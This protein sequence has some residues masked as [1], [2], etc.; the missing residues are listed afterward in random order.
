MKKQYLPVILNNK[1]LSDYSFEY[2]VRFDTIE[3]KTP[4]K[5]YDTIEKAESVIINLLSKNKMC[6]FTILT[7]YTN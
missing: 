1:S 4:L 2:R 3:N 7:I 5:S 6:K